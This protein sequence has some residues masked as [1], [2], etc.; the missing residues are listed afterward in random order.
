MSV[1]ENRKYI[2]IGLANFLSIHDFVMGTTKGLFLR[3]LTNVYQVIFTEVTKGQNLRIVVLVKFANNESLGGLLNCYSVGGGLG[4][5]SSWSLDDVDLMRTETSVID[6]IRRIAIPWLS[7]FHNKENCSSG[8]NTFPT[9]PSY[10]FDV[11][12]KLQLETKQ[13]KLGAKKGYWWSNYKINRL[14]QR[15]F[16]E[17]FEDLQFSELCEIES[18]SDRV[19]TRKRGDFVDV[20]EI[21]RFNFNMSLGFKVY[22]WTSRLSLTN[23]ANF[24]D[25]DRLALFDGVLMSGSVTEN[26]LPVV[27]TLATE[28]PELLS[29]TI[30]EMIE[31]KLKEYEGIKTMKDYLER[32]P[33]TTRNNVVLKHLGLLVEWQE[34]RYEN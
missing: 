25:D 31:I 27:Q 7:I 13:F 12:K 1:S 16:A 6:S 21:I 23:E 2:E 4:I 14:I 15:E 5:S 29:S 26:E 3:K 19:W 24:G 33:E 28:S 32:V 20:I 18:S 10:R 9:L 8:K 22:C 34:A 11:P 17:H 30:L